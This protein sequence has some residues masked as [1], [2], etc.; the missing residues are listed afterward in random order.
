M[1]DLGDDDVPIISLLRATHIIIVQHDDVDQFTQIVCL[2]LPG[3]HHITPSSIPS[4]PIHPL[5]KQTT[6]P[7]CNKNRTIISADDD[8]DDDD[9]SGAE[10][11]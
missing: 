9:V 2:A 5:T 6:R 11:S 8:D 3:H 10:W 7:S 1:S 4:H